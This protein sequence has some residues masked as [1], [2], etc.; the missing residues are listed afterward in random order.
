MIS[1]SITFTEINKLIY[2]S[3]VVLSCLFCTRSWIII[4]FTEDNKIY[5]LKILATDITIIEIVG[6][7]RVDAEF[8]LITFI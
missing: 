3:P 1:Y 8:V 2:Q 7:E 4:P 5:K 6:V